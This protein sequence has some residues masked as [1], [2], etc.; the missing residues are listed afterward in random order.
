[1]ERNVMGELNMHRAAGTKPNFSDIARRHGL[2]R[3]TV[4]KYW[5]EGAEVED[6]RSE[7]ESAFERVRPVVEA[8]AQLPGM[9]KRAV[10]ELLAHRYGDPP[11]PGYGAFTAW[12]RRQG[13]AFGRAAAPEAHPRFET[14]P[15]RQLQ[16][17]WKEGMRLVDAE[18]EL[19]E[20]SVFTA[21]LGYSRRHVFIPTRSRTTDDLLACLL[22]TF[23]TLGGAPEELVTDNMSAVVAFEGGRRRR[24]ER[25]ER[26]AREAGCRLVLCRPR[27]P[28]TKGKDESANRFLSRLS[29]YAGEFAGWEGLLEC[30]AR[31]ERRSNEEPNGTTGVPPAALFMR[32]KEA[33]RPIGNMRLLESMVGDVSVQ[34]VPPTMLVRA[35]GRQWSVPR[36]CIGRRV[37]VVAMPGGQV[38]VR[39]GGEEV[40]A[41]D[42]SGAAGPIVYQ[43][44]H[45]MEA[46][47]GK[48]WADGDIRAAARANLDL[49]DALGGGGP[50]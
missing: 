24:S 34:T 4:A 46:L 49:L 39:M 30:V 31:V 12:C 8:K 16:F 28:E 41:H 27:S 14:P 20:F 47:D 15:G 23:R 6:R 37:T 33:L 11:L 18:G 25:V 2:D 7:R 40:A 22:A 26:F 21:T 48:R 36:R 10:Y 38:R 9:T 1:M 13:I 3:H 44:E 17:D 45:Y 50:K 19:H 42:A 43:E 32:E 29:A 5:R 35:A